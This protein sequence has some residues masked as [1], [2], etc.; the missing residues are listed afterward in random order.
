M[1]VYR[2]ENAAGEGV[3]RAK[4]WTF[5]VYY[6]ADSSRHPLPHDDSALMRAIPSDYLHW[7]GRLRACLIYG[8]SS[9][10]QLRCWFYADEWRKVM[11]E[12]G[13]SVSVYSGFDSDIYAGDTQAVFI[14][15]NCLLVSK[16]SLLDIEA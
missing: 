16:F 13:F 1:L 9:L 10:D 8:F 4:G 6:T 14:K 15:D 11:H 5:G 2:I 7:D 3:Y 12:N